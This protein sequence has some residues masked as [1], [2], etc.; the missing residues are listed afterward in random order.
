MSS[1]NPI[2]T[3]AALWAVRHREGSL[4]AEEQA[5]FDAWLEKDPRHLGAFVR[6]RAVQKDL[7]RLAAVN[8]GKPAD[9]TTAP[10]GPYRLF[11]RAAAASILL[12]VAASALWLGLRGGQ[13]YV[14]GV[15]EL[16]QVAL[17]DGSHMTLN[18]ATETQVQ[19]S[20]ASRE[21][22]LSR[23]EALFEV[24]HDPK[25][26]FVVE[27]GPVR[28]TALGTA[29][30]VR[31]QGAR[32][33]VTVTEGTV[34]VESLASSGSKPR[35]VTA[36]QRVTASDVGFVKVEPMKPEV[37]ERELA[38]RQGM[39][40]FNGESLAEA[41]AVLNQHNHNH[42]RIVIADPA[43]GARPIIGMFRADDIE[44]F[45]RTAAA[46]TDAEVVADD[47]GFRLEAKETY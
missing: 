32:V 3:A 14:S 17:V 18:T 11:F 4:S 30:L 47:N 26:P 22:R 42:K 13:H 43:I 37:I 8:A 10:R 40:V 21:V 45:A 7:G 24:A 44:T 2:D 38:W 23:G 46:I 12:A 25:R 5:G 29:F 1:A 28:V 20:D 36:N 9:T 35:R 19:F 16:R 39:V 31:R 15:G 6:L 33:D 27:A 41:I 34:Q